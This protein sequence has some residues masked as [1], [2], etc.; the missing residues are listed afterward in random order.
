MSG[1]FIFEFVQEHGEMHE[2]GFFLCYDNTF[3]D[4]CNHGHTPS[5]SNM[6]RLCHV[7][8]KIITFV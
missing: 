5:I 6:V 3:C 1:W 7:I 2:M 8:G 4:K